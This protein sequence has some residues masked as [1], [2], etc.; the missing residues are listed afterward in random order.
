MKYPNSSLISPETNCESQIHA[1]LALYLFLFCHRNNVNS[2]TCQCPGEY[3]HTVDCLRKIL[4]VVN[5][6]G[7]TAILLGDAE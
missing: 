5:E 4:P 1:I 3:L 7:C 2:L 6:H